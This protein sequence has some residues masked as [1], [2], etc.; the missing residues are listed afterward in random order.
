MTDDRCLF[1]MH[2]YLKRRSWVAPNL[3]HP[4]F[5]SFSVGYTIWKS[6]ETDGDRIS[7]IRNAFATGHTTTNHGV[8]T[9]ISQAVIHEA[10]FS[11]QDGA[12]AA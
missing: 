4:L 1:N 5:V 6:I 9:V 3:N 12:S 11:I 7:T 8:L 10:S 2:I